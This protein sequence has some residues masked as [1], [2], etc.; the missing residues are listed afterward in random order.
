MKNLLTIKFISIRYR[1]F[2]FLVEKE[3]DRDPSDQIISDPGGS[4]TLPERNKVGWGGGH[5]EH[6]E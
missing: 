5:S 1:Y 4:G 6:N 3:E 2:S